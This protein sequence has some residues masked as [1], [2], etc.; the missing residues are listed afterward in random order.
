MDKNS[1][2]ERPIG[3]SIEMG[4]TSYDTTLD[5]RIE[6]AKKA[7]LVSK[8]RQKDNISEK[9]YQRNT[10]SQNTAVKR[11]TNHAQEFKK[12]SKCLEPVPKPY[13]EHTKYATGLMQRRLEALKQKITLPVSN[14]SLELTKHSTNSLK[15]TYIKQPKLF[16]SNH[17]VTS[18]YRNE[19]KTRSSVQK[20]LNHEQNSQLRLSEHCKNTS[21]MFNYTFFF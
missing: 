16:N 7:S 14:N 6:A 12:I 8:L 11:L 5:E 4:T 21:S 2:F 13:F 18:S 20:N 15:Q 3:Y 9:L 17:T 10:H 19:Y 1:M